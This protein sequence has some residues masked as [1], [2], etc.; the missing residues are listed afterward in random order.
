M[1]CSELERKISPEQNEISQELL[2]R[3]TDIN[4]QSVSLLFFVLEAFVAYPFSKCLCYFPKGTTEGRAPWIQTYSDRGDDP[5][6]LRGPWQ[7]KRKK[8]LLQR[9]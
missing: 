7:S 6:G 5:V 3:T 4:W 8:S 1:D 2:I 9:L